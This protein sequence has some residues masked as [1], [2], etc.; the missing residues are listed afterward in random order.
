MKTTIKVGVVSALLL[1]SSFML[2]GCIPLI[3]GGA[4][5]AAVGVDSA[6]SNLS[7][8]AQANDVSLK[9][10]TNAVI[11]KMPSLRDHS[12]IS[13]IV[14]NR[15]VLLLGQVPTQQAKTDLANKVA[16]IPGV[17]VVYNQL[18]VGKPVPFSRY[19]KDAWITTKVKTDFVGKVNLEKSEIFKKHSL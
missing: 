4:A 13:P 19:T 12:N 7:L 5:V 8:S 1:G 11:N 15:I 2:T 16:G 3:I 17:R 9:S 14:F 18:T 10:Q 6:A